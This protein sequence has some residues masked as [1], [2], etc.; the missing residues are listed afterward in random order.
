MQQALVARKHVF[1]EKPLPTAEE[2][3]AIED[4]H[5][6]EQLLMVGFNRRFVKSL[7]FRSSSGI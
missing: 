2:L 4:A 7:T 3:A 5:T 6:G 1:V